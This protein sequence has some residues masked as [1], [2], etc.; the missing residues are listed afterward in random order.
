MFGNFLV[1]RVNFG[2]RGVEGPPGHIICGSVFTLICSR[3]ILKTTS[4]Q[5][6]NLG[7]SSQIPVKRPPMQVLVKMHYKT[8]MVAL[9]NTWCTLGRR[10][11]IQYAVDMVR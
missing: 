1:Y 10:I 5:F 9:N 3:L 2:K 4:R 8:P 7:P 6:S 11:Q